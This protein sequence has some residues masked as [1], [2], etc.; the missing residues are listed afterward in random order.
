MTAQADATPDSA[1][2]PCSKEQIA[3]GEDTVK[4]N[5]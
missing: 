4:L 3:Y 5:H 2:V 1:A